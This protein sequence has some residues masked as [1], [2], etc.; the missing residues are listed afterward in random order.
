[1][2]LYSLLLINRVTLIIHNEDSVLLTTRV[3]SL[4]NLRKNYEMMETFQSS[5]LYQ[6]SV[7]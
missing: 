4:S 1:M 5:Q 6:P 3:S 7:E 2:H